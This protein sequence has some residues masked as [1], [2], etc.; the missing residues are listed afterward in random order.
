[1]FD[2]FNYSHTFTDNEISELCEIRD[3]GESRV[4]AKHELQIMICCD[5]CKW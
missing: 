2:R 4:S 1:M 3:L 5:T